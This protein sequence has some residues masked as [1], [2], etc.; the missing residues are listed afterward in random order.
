M[1]HSAQITRDNPTCMIFLVDQ[2]KSM[3]QTFGAQPDKKKKDGVTDAINRLLQGICITCAKQDGIREYF[4]IGV[5]GYGGATAQS[6]FGGKLAGR[7][8]VGIKE[9]ANNPLR[10]EKRM[11][12]QDDGVGG[13]FEQE[14]KFPVWFEPKADG[15]TPMRQAFEL[16][17]TLLQGFL[18]DHPDCLPPVVINFTDGE[19]GKLK[20]EDPTAAA[21][22]VRELS[23]SDG[24]VLVFNAHITH[25][26][27]PPIVFP[28][29]EHR[30]P[31]N[32]AKQLFRISSELPPK[33]IEQAQFKELDVMPGARGFMFNAD[34]ISVVEFLDVGTPLNLV[35]KK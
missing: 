34:L 1:S 31:N 17:H 18:S 8:L 3:D 10:V 27:D 14:L 12:K 28:D 33:M 35:D 16:A 15:K 19:W 30:L 6:A 13:I 7:D 32:F 26:N 9:I 5:I 11:R 21:A 23:S 2:S 29:L 25:L 20:E 22:A 4:Q 24:H